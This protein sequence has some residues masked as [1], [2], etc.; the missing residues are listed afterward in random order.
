VYLISTGK[1][2]SFMTTFDVL[3]NVLS[4]LAQSDWT[5]K[6]IG[7]CSSDNV[8]FADWHLQF[9]VV[10]LNSSGKL[11]YTSEMSEFTFK[12]VQ[13]EAQRAVEILGRNKLEGFQALF[14]KHV[15]FFQNFDHILQ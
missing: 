10:F 3:R 11:N 2:D 8:S 14:C 15:P 5:T 7:F 6:G 12:R 9:D 4:N 1:I 13:R